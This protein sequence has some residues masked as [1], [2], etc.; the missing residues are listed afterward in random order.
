MTAANAV[1]ANTTMINERRE[2][3]RFDIEIPASIR[4][5]DG[6]RYDGKTSNISN[7]GAFFKFSDSSQLTKETHCI[8][9]LFLEGKTIS[10]ELKIKCVFKPSRKDG[11]GLEFKTITTND[12]INFVFLLTKSHPKSEELF[13]VLKDNPGMQLVGEA[14]NFQK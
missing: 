2:Q 7:G 5:K 6:L 9:T 3:P 14:V 12:Y 1:P 10:E 4:L 13:T 8:L 11:A